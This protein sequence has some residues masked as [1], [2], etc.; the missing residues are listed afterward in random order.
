VTAGAVPTGFKRGTLVSLKVAPL[1][2]RARAASLALRKLPA[3]RRDGALDAIAD[4]IAQQ[5]G[6]ILSANAEDLTRAEAL[7]PALK[8]RLRLDSARVAA[9]VRSVREVRGQADPLSERREL[10]TGRSGVQVMKQ[11]VPLGVIAIVYEARPGVTAECAA[12]TLKSGNAVVLRGGKEAIATNQAIARAVRTGL[13]RAELPEDAVILIEDTSREAVI[14][15]LEASGEIDLLIPR[16]GE[17]L[18]A[19]V[20]QHA[21]VPVVRHG[22]GICQVYVDQAAD[23]SMAIEVAFNAKAQRPGVCNAMET[24]LLHSERL[25]DVLPELARRLIGAG[26]QLRADPAAWSVLEANRLEAQVASPTDWDTEFLGPVLA[27]RT[28]DG[29]D[30]ALDHIAT[31]GTHHT[32]AIVTSDSTRARRFLD[33]VDASCV[34][35]NA[36]TRLNDGGELGLGA[37]MG[38]ST[39]KMH[40][41]GPMSATEL[42]AEKW[43]VVGTGQI[44]Q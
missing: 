20:D 10:G 3:S 39:S 32:A 11:R 21:R 37:E 40:A 34:L 28:V 35:W 22:Q 44:R 8:D 29:L 25:S 43:V 31:H 12:L 7:P 42:T 6:Q 4:A 30:A 5:E 13:S 2:E 26:I 33:E 17:Q 19:L 23:R 36:S 9:L 41:Y 14:E 38:I 15:L 18:M 24:L 27:I 16:G 1:L